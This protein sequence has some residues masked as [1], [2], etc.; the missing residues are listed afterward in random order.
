MNDILTLSAAIGKF[1]N[2]RPIG[3][4]RADLISKGNLMVMERAARD[5]NKELV[6]AGKHAEDYDFHYGSGLD[7]AEAEWTGDVLRY[8]A[9]VALDPLGIGYDP[10]KPETF[11]QEIVTNPVG[12]VALSGVIS[13]VQRATSPYIVSD[14]MGKLMSVVPVPFGKT[15]EIRIE[16]NA[17][18]QWRDSDWT[19][20]RSAPS[21]RLYNG[22]ITLNPKPKSCR[23][24]VNLYELRSGG[25]SLIQ[26]VLAVSRGR[27]SLMMERFTQAF[28]AAADEEAGYIP[29]SRRESGYTDDNWARVIRNVSAAN[30]VPHTSLVAYGDFLAMR[31]VVPSHATLASAIMSGMGAEYFKRGY[32]TD[33]DGVMLYVVQPTVKPGTENTTATPV[34]PTDLIVIAAR[35]NRGYAPMICGMEEGGEGRVVLTPGEN[36]TETGVLEGLAYASFDIQPAFASAIGLIENVV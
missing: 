25:A 10:A 32:I 16:T 20:L 5:H 4:Q 35:A 22:C 6:A 28:V 26:T 8:C 11:I 27:A 12:L 33:H 36:A 14:M 34:F 2:Q 21:D 17:V 30:G 7:R 19:S 24:D 23:F 31:R 3:E 18:F 29:S 15:K 13:E 1:A 9:K